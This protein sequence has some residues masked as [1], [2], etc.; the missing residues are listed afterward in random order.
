MGY[1]LKHALKKSRLQPAQQADSWHSMKCPIPL[2][3]RISNMEKI[4]ILQ[5][6]RIS[7][8]LFGF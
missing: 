8:D 2:F 7:K 6:L 5:I 3:C 4:Q 1:D